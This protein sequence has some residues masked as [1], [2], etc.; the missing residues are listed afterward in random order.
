M[1]RTVD[2]TNKA[3]LPT[4]QVAP[5]VVVAARGG[6]LD[7]GVAVVEPQLPGEQVAD[8]RP[9]AQAPAHAEQEADVQRPGDAL[10]AR[11]YGATVLTVLITIELAWFALLGFGIYKLI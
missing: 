8:A 7:G 1:Q 9:D 11:I 3:D 4:S 5:R 10:G 2:P 6:T